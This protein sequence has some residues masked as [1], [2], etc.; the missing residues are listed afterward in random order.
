MESRRERIC[1]HEVLGMTPQ[2]GDVQADNFGNYLIPPVLQAQIELITTVKVLLPMERAIQKRLWGLM[3]ANNTES[4]FTIYLSMFILMHN[5]ALLTRAER[6]RAKRE[7]GSSQHYAQ[8]IFHSP[9]S[10]RV[11]GEVSANLI[12]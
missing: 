1:G 10:S 6:L 7:P 11:V 3:K 4:W 8:V 9:I 5:C 2:N 12:N